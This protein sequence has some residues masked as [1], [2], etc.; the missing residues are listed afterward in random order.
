MPGYSGTPL[1]KK[2]GFKPGMRA[3]FVNATPEVFAE[4]GSLADVTQVGPMA[5][6][7]DIVLLFCTD[8]AALKRHFQKFAARLKPA[9]MIWVGWP[10]KSSGVPTD[11]S[12]DIVRTYGLQCGLVDVKV[13]AITDIWSGHKFVI[14]VKDR[15]KLA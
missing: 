2:L 3:C 14:R 8:F 15:A 4:L 6:N 7:L 9:G 1:P 12:E 10:K 5:K 13:C 11:L